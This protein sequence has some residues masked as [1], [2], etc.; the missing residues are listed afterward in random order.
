MVLQSTGAFTDYSESRLKIL[1]FKS[2]S[3]DEIY[4]C[5]EGSQK[6]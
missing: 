5:L 2:A 6:N 1:T 3:K 4:K